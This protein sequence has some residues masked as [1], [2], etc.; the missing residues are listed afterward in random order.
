MGGNSCTPQTQSSC[1]DPAFWEKLTRDP[2][3]QCVGRAQAAAEAA[4]IGSIPARWLLLRVEQDGPAYAG[5]GKCC[6]LTGHGESFAPSATS[7]VNVILRYSS[8]SL[9]SVFPSPEAGA[10]EVKIITFESVITYTWS[11]SSEVIKRISFPGIQMQLPALF[12]V[13]GNWA[14][15]QYLW[16]KSN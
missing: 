5:E 6:T 2:R 12:C 10:A 1:W 15:K 3:G 14:R 11:H 16:D 9:F 4:P 8:A 7:G 13:N